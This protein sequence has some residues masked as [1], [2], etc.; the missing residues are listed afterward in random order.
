MLLTPLMVAGVV[1]AAQEDQ[2]Y[3]L[4]WGAAVLGGNWATLGSA[5]LEDVLRANPGMTGSVMP[6]G[7]TA[8]V[9]GVFQGKLNIAFT[10]A[11]VVGEAWDGVGSFAALGKIRNLRILASL[12]PEPSQF[13]VYADSGI[14]TIPQLKGR[15]ITAGPKGGGT[16]PLTIKILEAY[17]MTIKDVQWT[18]LPFNG[19]VEQML[20][21]HL[22]ALAYGAMGYPAPQILNISS[23][24]KTRMLSL[25]DEVVAKLVKASKGIE[26]YTLPTNSYKGIDY[27]VKGIS[28]SVI[29]IAHETMPEDVA[30]RVTKTLAENFDRYAGTVKAMALGKATEMGK[31]F[32]FPQ[33]PG[34]SKYYKEK[35]WIK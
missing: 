14:T 8:N 7:G 28:S 24:H 4:R 18:P 10:K 6:I 19:G 9:M 15:R 26:P 22:D 20:D 30:Y 17:G 5:M 23:V 32:G 2:K 34:A 31:S 33:H 16:E 12:F 11:D 25:S 21:R 1:L 35:G 29:L 27:P 3:E 13:L